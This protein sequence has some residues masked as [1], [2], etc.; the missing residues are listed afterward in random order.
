[1]LERI[2]T[3]S[4]FE[5]WVIHVID[6]LTGVADGLQALSR[7]FVDEGTLGDTLQEVARLACA[8]SP[9]ELAG[10]TLLVDGKLATAVFTDPDAPEI[11][12]AQYETGRGPCL[13]AFRDQQ[14]Y[15]IDS[16]AGEDR[17]PEFALDAA[18]HGITATLSLLLGARGKGLGALNL[19]SRGRAIDDEAAAPGLAAGEPKGARHRI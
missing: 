1:L 4:P 7:F 17:W 12:A 16:M 9:A 15:R 3:G 18:R 13:D 2:P 11:D 19:Y 5:R 14:V 8:V 6:E 10:I